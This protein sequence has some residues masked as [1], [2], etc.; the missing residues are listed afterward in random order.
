MFDDIKN[1][2]GP[3]DDPDFT[4]YTY[5]V[6]GNMILIDTVAK[7]PANELQKRKADEWLKENSRLYAEKFMRLWEAKFGPIK[8]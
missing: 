2:Y 3:E 8:G 5:L 1:P 7:N 4:Q 6:E